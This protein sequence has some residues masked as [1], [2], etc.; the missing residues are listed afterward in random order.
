MTLHST[1]IKKKNATKKI[2][3]LTRASW[4]RLNPFKWLLYESKNTARSLHVPQ[5]QKCNDNKIEKWKFT[6]LNNVFIE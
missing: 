4:P 2:V 6:I 5:M 3:N 1:N